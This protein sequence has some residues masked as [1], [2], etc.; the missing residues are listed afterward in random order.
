MMDSMKKP[1]T[2]E[3]KMDSMKKD[4]V[5]VAKTK[6]GKF[7]Y[8]NQ[9]RNDFARKESPLSDSAEKYSNIVYDAARNMSKSDLA[10]KDITK[11]IT[12]NSDT[13]Y[14]YNSNGVNFERTNYKKP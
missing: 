5:D 7:A 14:K 6:S 13:V 9:T 11:K 8:K 3:S 12:K 1:V 4:S 10:K 2:M